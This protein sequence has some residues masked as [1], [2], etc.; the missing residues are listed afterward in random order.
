MAWPKQPI[1]YT[2]YCK[3]SAYHAVT[4][5]SQG[6]K[7]EKFS[8]QTLGTPHLDLAKKMSLQTQ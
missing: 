4:T 1:I 3:N 8:K 6:L 2:H 7:P 5:E